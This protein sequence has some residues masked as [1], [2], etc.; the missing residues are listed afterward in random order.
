LTQEPVMGAVRLAVAAA[1][2]TV[3]VPPYIDSFRIASQ[4]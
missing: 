3:R 2:G 4:P 1:T